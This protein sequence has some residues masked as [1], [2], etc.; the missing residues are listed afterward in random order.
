MSFILV[1]RKLESKM[2]TFGLQL[3]PELSLYYF[4][5]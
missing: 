3:S 1:L 2:T 4:D 5:T